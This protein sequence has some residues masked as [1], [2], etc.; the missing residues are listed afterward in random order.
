MA[1]HRGDNEERSEKKLSKRSIL[2]QDMAFRRSK[3][4][5]ASSEKKEFKVFFFFHDV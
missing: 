1:S 3:L 5:K 2:C 4:Q